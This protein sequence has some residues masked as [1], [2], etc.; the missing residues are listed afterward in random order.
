MQYVLLSAV[1]KYMFSH[2]FNFSDEIIILTHSLPQPVNFR[3]KMC[4]HTHLKTVFGGPT[5]N[6]PSILCILTETSS[7]THAKGGKSLRGFKF[8]TLVGGFPSDGE[9]SMEV[10]GLNLQSR[11]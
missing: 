5:T 7:R 11:M 2:V 9:A 6:L 4:L 8:G 1:M 3:A 10:K